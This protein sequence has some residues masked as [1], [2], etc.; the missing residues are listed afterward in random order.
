MSLD[1]GGWNVVG[2]GS[3]MRVGAGADGIGL[4]VVVLEGSV[5]VGVG[6][7][8]VSCEED[9]GVGFVRGSSGMMSIGV[10]GL[11]SRGRELEPRYGGCR[12]EL[13]RRV[14]GAG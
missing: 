6:M 7:A 2:R 10:A 8:M 1:G 14:V 9:E 11:S 12:R 4:G 13:E 3:G 5:V